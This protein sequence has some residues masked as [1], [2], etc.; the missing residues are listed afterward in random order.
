MRFLFPPCS[1]LSILHV[2]RTLRAPV[3]SELSRNVEGLLDRGKRWVLLDLSR[4]AD[5]DAAGVGELVRAFN[6]T[7]A[8]G[9]VL[10]ITHPTRRVRRL[11]Q[12]AG[13]LELLSAGAAA[14]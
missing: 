13:V 4:L 9:G 8:A 3:D 5:I 6:T 11:L 12:T 10:R 1:H 2:E 7:T 14:A